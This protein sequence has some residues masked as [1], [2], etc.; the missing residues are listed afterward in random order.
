MSKGHSG[1]K[2]RYLDGNK[3]VVQL[4]VDPFHRKKSW[5]SFIKRSIQEQI[6][7]ALCCVVDQI[8]NEM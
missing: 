3:V 2:Q 4:N 8:C 5:P 1:F 6:S 7:M